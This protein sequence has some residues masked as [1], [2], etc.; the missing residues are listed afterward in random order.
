MITYSLVLCAKG[1]VFLFGLAGPKILPVWTPYLGTSLDCIL[2]LFLN[3]ES[4]I[5]RFEDKAELEKFIKKPDKLF[6]MGFKF[7]DQVSSY[8]NQF[9]AL[10]K[11][12]SG[13]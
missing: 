4:H 5:L 11:K 8:K 3:Q 7:Q 1:D 13:L 6:K 12:L 2:N 10:Y 9:V